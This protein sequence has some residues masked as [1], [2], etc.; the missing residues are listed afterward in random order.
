VHRFWT[1]LFEG[2][3]LPRETVT[4]L[5]RPRHQS[6]DGD[7]YGLGFWLYGAGSGVQLEGYDAGVSFRSRHDP[8]TGTTWTVAANTSEGAWPVAR[9]L[10]EALGQGLGEGV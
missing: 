8:V 4:E 9:A 3:I 7:R 2:R 6:S 10:A 1:A 5:V